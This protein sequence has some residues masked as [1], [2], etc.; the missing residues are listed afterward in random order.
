MCRSYLYSEEGAVF[1][2]EGDKTK[3][4]KGGGSGGVV[5]G[6]VKWRHRHPHAET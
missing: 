1:V 5:G 3:G 2:V 4:E 6:D